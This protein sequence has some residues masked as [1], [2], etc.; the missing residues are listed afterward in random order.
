MIVP[1]STNAVKIMTI[2]ASKGLEFPVV[3]VP[4]CNWGVYQAGD[5][6]V[7]IN[8]PKVSLPVGVI[9]LTN[10]VKD[11]GFEKELT[12]EQKALRKEMTEKYDT[13]KDGKLDKEERAKISAEDKQKMEHAGLGPKKK[14]NADAPK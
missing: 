4:Y 11:S 5:S 2:H 14:T 1:D 7:S 9:N 8:D 12:A 10:K 3:I 13:N 6:W